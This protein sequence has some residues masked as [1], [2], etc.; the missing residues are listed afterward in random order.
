MGKLVGLNS[1]PCE[2]VSWVAGRSSGRGSHREKENEILWPLDQEDPQRRKWQSTPV[3][4]PG[5]SNRQG[6]LVDYILWGCKELGT[7]EWL[8]Q[9]QLG[10][11]WF[12]VTSIEGSQRKTRKWKWKSMEFSRGSSQPR[13]RIQVS[14]IAGGFF[15]SW[16]TREAQD[17]WSG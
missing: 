4:L 2:L 16:A 14:H 5:K 9:L 10:I 11:Q 15:T 13:D 12:L 3:F 6:S 1:E 17:Y 7:T 8:T